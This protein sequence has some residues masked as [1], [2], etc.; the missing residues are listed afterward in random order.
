MI[1][2]YLP[3]IPPT[4]THQEK[5]VTVRGGKPKFY[6]DDRLKAARAQLM[7]HLAQHRP[8][9]PLYGA[10]VLRTLWAYPCGEVHV[11]GEP[12]STKPDTDNIQK[13]LKDCMTELGYW[14]D[15]A[16]VAT[17]TITKMWSRTPGIVIE[18]ITWDETKGEQK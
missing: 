3:M 17:E 14:H 2:M 1:Q 12:R 9:T 5:R 7:A 16:Q 4:V 18:V 6:E 13:L 8:A 11:D 10:L 15:D